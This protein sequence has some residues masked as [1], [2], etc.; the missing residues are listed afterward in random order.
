LGGAAGGELGLGGGQ[1]SI[2]WNGR[3]LVRVS[4]QGYNAPEDVEA[5]I[6]ALSALLRDVY[7]TRFAR[8]L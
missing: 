4:V 5:L 2:E 6:A 7:T 1:T 3:Q 8:L